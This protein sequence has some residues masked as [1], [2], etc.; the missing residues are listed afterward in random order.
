[1][2]TSRL[3]GI[4]WNITATQLSSPEPVST[5]CVHPKPQKPRSLVFSHHSGI[6]GQDIDFQKKY[7]QPSAT[8]GN[9]STQHLSAMDSTQTGC[10][11]SI[12]SGWK[13]P[14]WESSMFHVNASKETALKNADMEGKK[15]F[16]Q[17]PTVKVMCIHAPSVILL[18]NHSVSR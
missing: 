8:W 14:R 6:V 12:H 3:C 10:K 15:C 5:N 16:I 7:S 17:I 9:S 2:Y 1:M 11:P 18:F 13:L 4:V